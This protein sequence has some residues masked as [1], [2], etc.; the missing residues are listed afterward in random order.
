[1]HPSVLFALTLAPAALLLALFA[2]LKRRRRLVR[3]AEPEATVRTASLNASTVNESGWWF[4]LLSTLLLLAGTAT[5]LALRWQT[6][7]EHFPVH[8]GLDGQPNGWANR[9]FG[10]IFGPLLFTVVIVGGLGLLGELIARSSP[11]HESRPAMIRTTRTVLIA[12]SWF[13]TILLCSISLLPLS[14][15]PTNL[16]PFLSMSAVVFSLGVV[17]YV[18]FRAI[19][20]TRMTVAS[21][22]STDARFWKAGFLYFNPED[23]TLM[24]PKRQGFGYTLNFGRP[25]CWLIFVFILLLPLILILFLH[26]SSHR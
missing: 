13:V 5:L 19:R 14:Q 12:C 8:W 17:G 26:V 3:G 2:V 16:V 7:P 11:G 9:S 1:M 23:S 24:V 18:A 25:V 22:N 6:L 21:Q 20:M 4:G 10:S 15:N